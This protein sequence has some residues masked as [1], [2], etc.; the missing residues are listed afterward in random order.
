MEAECRRCSGYPLEG[1][2][3]GNGL[4]G[5][6]DVVF[7]FQERS[8]GMADRKIFRMRRPK[9]VVGTGLQQLAGPE[10]KTAVS[11]ISAPPK[12]RPWRADIVKREKLRCPG[13]SVDDEAVPLNEQAMLGVDMF[14]QPLEDEER[15]VAR[16]PKVLDADD[17]DRSFRIRDVGICEQQ[18]LSEIDLSEAS[19]KRLDGRPNIYGRRGAKRDCR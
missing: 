16:R 14:V 2:L 9:S 19:P 7:V 18:G 11:D 17:T 1:E 13:L 4:V 12:L 6:A 10:R 3:M 8:I 5:E 15:I